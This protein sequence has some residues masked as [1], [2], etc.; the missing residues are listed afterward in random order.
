MSH[1]LMGR[2]NCKDVNSPQTDIQCNTNQNHKRFFV[3]FFV[4]LIKLILRLT[5]KYKG[6]RIDHLKEE[7]TR[8]EDLL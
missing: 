7:K 6:P 3:F 1:S 5:W 4:K 2:L 8:W